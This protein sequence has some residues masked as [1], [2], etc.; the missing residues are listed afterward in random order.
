MTEAILSGEL[1]ELDAVIIGIGI[2]TGDVPFALKEFA[3][4]VREENGMC[5]IRNDLI[6]EVLTQ[7]ETIYVDYT[8]NDKAYEIIQYYESNLFIKGKQIMVMNSGS[9]YIATVLGIDN[10][11]ALI[12]RDTDG[13][14]QHL[15]TGEIKIGS[16]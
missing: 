10:T 3:T 13:N 14:I 9:E 5:G 11:G 16:F 2:N 6:A 4:S 7:F 8:A 1:Q 15:V 12:V